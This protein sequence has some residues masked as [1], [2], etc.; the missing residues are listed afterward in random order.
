MKFHSILNIDGLD[1]GQ[2]L[3][4]LKPNQQKDI[5]FHT[6]LPSTGNFKLIA[7]LDQDDMMVNNRIE[8]QVQFLDNHEQV[9]AVGSQYWCINSIG[10]KIKRL[11]W[12]IGLENNLFSVIVGHVP[13]GDPGVMYRNEVAQNMRGYKQKYEPAED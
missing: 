4:T 13:I 10:E 6:T 9:A 3:V 8:K 1:I 2:Q 7:E 5:T 12:P 11:R